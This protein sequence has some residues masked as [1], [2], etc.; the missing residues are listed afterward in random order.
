MIGVIG[1]LTPAGGVRPRALSWSNAPSVLWLT[2]FRHA[3]SR[4]NFGAGDNDGRSEMPK[5]N[6]G[7]NDEAVQGLVAA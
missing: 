6:L 3:R 2:F 1:T 7:R 5:L 4:Y